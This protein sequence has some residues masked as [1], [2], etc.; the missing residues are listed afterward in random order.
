MGLVRFG[1]ID[2][3]DAEDG[4]LAVFLK[5]IRND[6]RFIPP[7]R[8]LVGP[9]IRNPTFFGVT[10]EAWLE[11]VVLAPVIPG[12]AEHVWVFPVDSRD[13]YMAQ[14]SG[15]GLSEYEGM[16]GMTVLREMDQ[17]GNTST[18]HLEWLPGNVA[19]FGAARAAVAA[20]RE[21]Y[22]EN[23]A[24]RGLLAGAGGQYVEPDV[25]VRLEPP[26]IAAWRETGQGGYWLRGKIEKMTADLVAYWQPNP[27]R[28][29]LIDSLA[30][31][32]SVWPR[33]VERVDV[34]VWFEPEGVEWKA[35][36]AI[37]SGHSLRSQLAV[38]RSMPERTALAYAKPVSDESFRELCGWGGRLLLDAAGG[39]VAQE[40]KTA[41][42]RF[43]ELLAGGMPRE[44]AMGWVAPPPGN[45]ELGAARLLVME[46]GRPDALE[47]AWKLFMDSLAPNSSV[48]QAFAQI[49][50]SVSVQREGDDSGTFTLRITSPENIPQKVYYDGLICGRM[51]GGRMAVVVGE[52]RADSAERRRIAEYRS[53][54]AVRATEGVPAGSTDVRRAFTRMGTNG[55]TFLGVFDPVRFLQVCLV[56][57]ADWRRR[58][59]DQPEPLETQ[60]ARE[61][62]EYGAGGAWTFEG[63]ATSRTWTLN[64]GMSWQSLSRLSA[65]L[66]VTESIGME[67]GL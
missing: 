46:W 10:Y 66:G 60:L 1:N 3:I 61:M 40:A 4:D 48:T 23:S 55:A 41:A 9:E 33:G 57:S 12:G 19:V 26:R 29:R 6:G 22:A 13:E 47:A 17:D 54:L 35:T 16:D 8:S 38:L 27:A 32:L 34:S 62:L 52:N 25:M 58:S 51:N 37:E 36:A 50:W 20:T 30:N 21:I 11:C 65:A 31:E 24:A 45:P 42:M 43:Q 18:W 56:E 44:A 39:V 49:G 5:S 67:S 53:D 14:L 15:L 28:L 64:G 2:A 59:P 63:E 7:L